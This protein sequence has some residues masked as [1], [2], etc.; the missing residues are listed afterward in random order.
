MIVRPAGLSI[1]QIEPCRHLQTS[2]WLSV[3]F[4]DYYANGRNC[5]NVCGIP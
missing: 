1:H 3:F 2:L 5:F 4:M